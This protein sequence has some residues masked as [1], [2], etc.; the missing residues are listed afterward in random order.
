M[1]A[2]LSLR[3]VF[4]DTVWG[5]LFKTKSNCCCRCLIKICILR[6]SL[7]LL[8]FVSSLVAQHVVKHDKQHILNGATLDVSLELLDD[9]ESTS[10]TI[11]ITGVAEKTTED[12]I[13]NYFENERR[14][15]GGEVEAVDL[16]PEEN[17]AF[18][19]FK[20]VDGK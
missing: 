8:H 6:F 3:F 13:S 19:T 14:S 2:L 18:V 16:R 15:G 5:F 9:A 17:V 7:H 10:K 4:F 1:Y 20:D 11:K 12:S